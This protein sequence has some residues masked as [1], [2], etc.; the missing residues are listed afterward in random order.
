MTAL[1][2][3]LAGLKGV[4]LPAYAKWAAAAAL[5]AAAYGV[6]RLHEARR[7]ADAMIA[8][9]AKQTAQGVR[10]VERQGKVVTVT[11]T[12]YR[13][14]IQTV[15]VKGEEIEKSIPVYVQPADVGRFAVNAGF[16][17]VLAAGWTGEAVGPA[18]DSDREPAGVPL[19]DIAA[20]EVHNATSC[21]AWRK[22]VIGWREFYAGQQVAINGQAGT[23][24]DSLEDDDE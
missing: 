1:A 8:Y 19:D 12:K 18:R 13:D 24:A 11:E 4:T 16:V 15:Y 5:M 9:Q 23:W 20:T 22:Q 7:G 10:I 6:G 17:R 3:R 21:R 14:R 2:A